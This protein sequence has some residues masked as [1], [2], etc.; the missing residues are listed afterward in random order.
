MAGEL[1]NQKIGDWLI[2]EYINCGKSAL[3]FRAEGRGKIAA[4]KIFD[5]EIVETFGD[6]QQLKRIE[7]EKSLIGHSHPNLIEIFDGG[8][9]LVNGAAFCYVVMEYFPGGNLATKLTLVPFENIWSIISQVALAAQF[10]ESQGLCHRDIKPE[11]IGIDDSMRCIKLLD[12]GVLRPLA[13]SDLTDEGAQPFIGTLRYAPPEFLLRVEDKTPDGWRAISFY[14]L[15]AVLH[16]LIMRTPLF[17]EFSQPYALLV[18]AVQHEKPKISSSQVAPDLVELAKRCLSK[19][20][21]MRLSIVSWEDF[22]QPKVITDQLKTIKDKISKRCIEAADGEEHEKPDQNQQRE[23]AKWKLKDYATQVQSIIRD[24]CIGSALF[25][26]L[27]LGDISSTEETYVQFIIWFEPAPRQQGL[28]T[29]L[30]L[31]LNLN[32]LDVED[33]LVVINIH[34][35]VSQSTIANNIPPL[36]DDTPIYRGSFN[37]EKITAAICPFIYAV[38]YA[39]QGFSSEEIAAKPKGLVVFGMDVLTDLK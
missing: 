7:R 31:V 19:K 27:T 24:E 1:T 18:N 33:D 15:G 12:L 34:A 37:Q 30:T 26:R 9:A 16:D 20:A 28:H 6:K 32:W 17:T 39:A 25:P 35:V 13:S 14:Q 21:K 36:P 22:H 4:I 29:Y 10:L 23:E 8:S 2:C 3:V 11:N 38:L 5:P